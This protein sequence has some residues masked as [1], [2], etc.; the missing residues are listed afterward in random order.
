[1]RDAAKAVLRLAGL[2]RDPRSVINGDIS[3]LQELLSV[4]TSDLTPVDRR[5][6]L[7]SAAKG[8]EVAIELQDQV[9]RLQTEAPEDVLSPPTAAS[10]LRPHRQAEIEQRIV[11]CLSAG[12][13]Q[14]ARQMAAALGLTP[15]RIGQ[16]CG[17]SSRCEVE[18]PRTGRADAVWRIVKARRKPR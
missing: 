11:D 9:E 14:S 3:E 12:G 5:A 6:L 7:V 15:A 1:L 2:L 4:P 8:L 10:R 17:A 13:P 16:V 18:R